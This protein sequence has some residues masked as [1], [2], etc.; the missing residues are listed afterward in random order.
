[1]TEAHH[2]FSKGLNSRAL[3]KVNNQALSEDLVQQTFLKTWAYLVKGGKVETMKA[4]LYHILNN[5][6]TDEYRKH[7][8]ISLESLEEKGF[9]PS[10]KRKENVEDVLD[11]RRAFLLIDLLPTLYVKIMKMKYRQDFSITEIASITK[12]SANTV[13]VQLHRGLEKLR[14]LFKK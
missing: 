11:G 7:K 1:M 3:F 10:D 5:L 13:T 6:I 8:T 4:F 14:V 12:Q 2:D 9:D